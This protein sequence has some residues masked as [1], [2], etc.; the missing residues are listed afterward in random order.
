MPTLEKKVER[1]EEKIDHLDALLGQF[2]SATG[3]AFIRLEREMKEFKDEMKEFKD[4]MKEFKDE[5]KEFKVEMSE[6]KDWSKANIENMNAQWGNL[7]KKM[8]TLIE[9]IFYPSSDIVIEKYF[10]MRPSAS[11]IRRRVRKNGDEFEADILAICRKEK[12]AFLF[13]IKAN[14][15]NNEYMKEFREKI[16]RAPEFLDDIKGL[17]LVPIYGGLSM[18]ETMVKSLTRNGIFGIIF[19]GDVLEIPNFS[20]VGSMKG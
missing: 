13:E 8:G 7:A 6:Y 10:N 16:D 9:D 1:N 3:A 2:L 19:K 15:N 11:M 12:T 18:N 4:E 17:K 20:Q 5:M 14:P